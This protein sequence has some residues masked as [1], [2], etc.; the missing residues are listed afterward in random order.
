MRNKTIKH[1]I[2][3]TQTYRKQKGGKNVLPPKE[4]LEIE[5]IYNDYFRGDAEEFNEKYD[6]ILKRLST[7]IET[8]KSIDDIPLKLNTEINNKSFEIRIDNIKDEYDICNGKIRKRQLIN[9]FNFGSYS[10]TFVALLKHNDN[11]I[12]ICMF[13]F[14]KYPPNFKIG[15]SINDSKLYISVNW[16]CGSKYGGVGRILFN[17]LKEIKEYVDAKLIY[18]TS[19]ASAVPFYEKM[20]M[21]YIGNSRFG[22]PIMGL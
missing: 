10:P 15:T 20:G 5:L 12:G 11:I 18:L 7:F 19:Y 14:T 1:K 16:L 13:N 17:M 8:V 4:E 22:T 3:R 21:K 6:V 2:N 9:A